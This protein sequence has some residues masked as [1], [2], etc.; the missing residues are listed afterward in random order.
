M[1][2]KINNY[3]ATHHLLNK[4]Q[5][6]V[7]GVS[8][9]ADSTALLHILHTLGYQCIIAHCNFKLR[10][11]ESERDEEFVRTMALEM[12]LPYESVHFETKQYASSKK[13]SIEMAARE[14]RY[15]WFNR[16]I[17]KYN[18]QAV[19]VAHHADDSVETILMNLVRGT[20]IR[21][22]SGIPPRNDNVIRP[23]L[24]CTRKEI[25]DY[26]VK[27]N[28]EHVDDSTNFQNEY[29][30]NK[31][32]NQVIPLLEEINPSV[33]IT[34]S[35][36]ARRFESY[37]NIF[38][39]YIGNIKNE[40]IS[41]ENNF[42]RIDIEKLKSLTE[43]QTLLFELL[44]PYKFSA[45]T[46][47]NIVDNLDDISGKR[48]YSDTHELI[49]DRNYLIIGSRSRNETEEYRININDSE[50][51]SPVHI[52][53]TI[54]NY[55]NEFIISKNQL[56]IHA[57]M[58]EVEFPLT[59]RKWRTGDSFYPFGMNHPK[60]LS[61]FMIDEKI[62]LLEKNNIWL[63]VSADKIMWVVGKRMDN[64]FKISDKTKKILEIRYK[65]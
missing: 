31:F 11:E 35:E 32:R 57:D 16:L 61:D 15:N 18:A 60:K 10:K 64:R 44:L 39:K 43:I 51:L 20:G 21:G 8:G 41:H 52:T 27:N 50:I 37:K 58:D 22:L 12:K 33:K 40:L 29:Q 7:I 1:L 28:L 23:L 24:C 2:Q 30:R 34:L 5:A 63:L 36:T 38:D 55:D 4:E 65:I 45:A 25:E 53:F 6:V 62:N 47:E 9:G 46:V 48:F 14:L 42:I 49:K 17:T 56:C 59:L 26:L 19:A 3:I 13:I 54:K